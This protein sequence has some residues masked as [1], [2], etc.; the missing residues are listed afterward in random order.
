MHCRNW[1]II[2]YDHLSWRIFQKRCAPFDAVTPRLPLSTNI[3]TLNL[4]SFVKLHHYSTPPT[5]VNRALS[6][7]SPKEAFSRLS[8]YPKVLFAIPQHTPRSPSTNYLIKFYQVHCYHHKSSE[9]ANL[10]LTNPPSKNT[11]EPHPVRVLSAQPQSSRSASRPAILP[12]P[13]SRAR[14]P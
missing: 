11:K 1:Y 14:S 2:W 6:D 13:A 5:P 9:I 8:L 4:H 7:K 10:F 3:R 12:L